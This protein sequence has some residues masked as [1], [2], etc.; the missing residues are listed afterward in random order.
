MPHRYGNLPLGTPPT[1]SCRGPGR[2][3]TRKPTNG[4]KSC[5]F[6][7]RKSWFA[8]PR[9]SRWSPARN[10]GTAAPHFYPANRD[11]R[12]SAPGQRFDL[13]RGRAGKAHLTHLSPTTPAFSTATGTQPQPHHH[14][15]L[16]HSPGLMRW[17]LSFSHRWTSTNTA[18]PPRPSTWRRRTATA[19]QRRSRPSTTQPEASTTSRASTSSSSSSS[20]PK[21]TCGRSTS[22]S[23]NFPTRLTSLLTALA[24]L[25]TTP[26]SCRTRA[27]PASPRGCPLRHATA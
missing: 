15:P 27:A 24:F 1:T 21:T 17:G 4:H 20:G 2:S 8:R 10:V 12:C 26:S 16:D 11:R 13:P 25:S 9:T 3:P 14:I 5:P 6:L 22:A 18:R 7:T 19:W 23:M